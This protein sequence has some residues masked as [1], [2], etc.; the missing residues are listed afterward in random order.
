MPKKSC[1]RWKPVRRGAIYCSPGCGGG[2]TYEAYL[3]ATI[4]AH[5]LALKCGHDFKPR[6]WENLGWYYAAQSPSNQIKVHPYHGGGGYTVFFGAPESPGGKYAYQD[7]TLK[8]AIRAGFD[9]VQK[10]ARDAA[11]L[12]RE[13]QHL[14]P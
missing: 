4:D 7:K 8:G 13:I 12:L 5:K 2:C 1:D 11:T 14:M 6:V 9:R 3:Q 10:D